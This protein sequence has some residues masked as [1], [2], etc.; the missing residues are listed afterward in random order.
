SLSSVLCL[1]LASVLHAQPTPP[2]P[3][4]WT[5]TFQDEFDGTALDGSKWKL[6]QGDAGIEGPGGN[7]P[8]NT[9]VG[10]GKLTLRASTDPVV[11]A[12]TNF[13]YSTGEISSYMRF[14]QTGGYLEARMRWDQ[15]TGLWPAFWVMPERDGYGTKEWFSRAF[16]KFNLAGSGVSSITSAKLRIKTIV[17]GNSSSNPNNLQTLAVTDDS[18][19][20]TGINWNN[21]PALNPLHLD[22][23]WGFNS[24]AGDIVEIDVTAWAQAQLAGDGV[25]SVALSDEFRR[26]RA[27]RFHSRNAVNAADRPVL[28]INGSVNVAP[29]ADAAVKWGSYSS[30]NYGS[31]AELEVRTDYAQSPNNS[32]TADGG[33]ELDIMEALGV[34]GKNVASHAIH[35]D[36]YGASQQSRGWGPVPALNTDTTYRTYGCYW[37][38][39]ELIEFYVDGVK[40]GSYTDS[41]VM[42]VPGYLILSLQLGGWDANNVTS[43]IHNKT[44]DVDYVRVWS[45]TKST[46]AIPSATSRAANGAISFGTDYSVYS[47]QPNATGQV[48]IADGGAAVTVHK[49]SWWK[50]PLNYTVTP[51]TVI[52]VTVESAAPGEIIAFGLENNDSH[53]DAKRLFHFAGSQVWTGAW[54]DFKDYVSASGPKTYLI[55]VGQFYTGA[56]THL[57]IANDNDAGNKAVAARYSNVRIHE[58]LQSVNFTSVEGYANGTL[59]N[60]PASAPAW[61]LV[62]GSGSFNINLASGLTVNTAQTTA[63][64]A[65]WQTP[66]SYT[67]TPSRT[68]VMDFGFTQSAATGGTATIVSLGHFYNATSATTNLRAYFGRA[69]GTDAY[70]I[71]FYQNNGSPATSLTANVA[72]SALGLNSTG[73]DNVSAPLQLS[74]TLNRGAT[75]SDWTATVTLKNLTSGSTVATL[76]VPAFITSATFFSDTSLYPSISSESIQSTALSQF[77]ITGYTSP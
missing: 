38:P 74:F 64:N 34:W 15:A 23:K 71:G 29:A 8:A 28:V 22:H 20:E 9:T 62:S 59:H 45:G 48:T 39:G 16:L 52:E 36:G 6:G 67:A 35:W 66:V 41:R 50:F 42:T 77:A 73:G 1:L 31:N 37:V 76:N 10:G 65:V 69:S 4:T 17:V 53:T 26:A 40:T 30:T 61:Q 14:K 72:G 21:Q 19:T 75:F 2:I 68:T 33:M 7:N 13:A 58:G 55:P 47:A 63:Q 11:F 18:W 60:Q 70:R 32:T 54:T 46:P 43:A 27:M 25:M 56:M 24:A 3:G 49:D 57:A 44:V 5:L 51:D 12:G